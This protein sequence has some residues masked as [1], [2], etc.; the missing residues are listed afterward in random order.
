[1]SYSPQGVLNK[2]KGI[3]SYI[4]TAAIDC[5][6]S[7]PIMIST[8]TLAVSANTL[9]AIPFICGT[10]DRIADRIAM[11][12]TTGSAGNARLGIYDDTGNLY[13][14]NLILDAGT[15]DTTSA[16]VK[17]IT[18]SQTLYADKLYWLAI[19]LNA[20]PILRALGN[21]SIF[22]PLGITS[23]LGVMNTQWSVAFTYAALPNPFTSEGSILTSAPVGIF[24]R[25]SS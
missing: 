16:G 12:A 6:Y 5:Y 4:R 2:S 19:V 10:E 13:P 3:Q 22:H 14:N 9:Y 21:T 17:T 18:I 11:N 8:S 1:M 23:T 24:L 25:F 7:Y 15:V 20:T